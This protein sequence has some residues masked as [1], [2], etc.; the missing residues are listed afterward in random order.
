MGFLLQSWQL[1]LRILPGCV[2]R[3]LRDGI[4]G[5][6]TET[7]TGERQLASRELN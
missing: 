6:R 7:P 5:L 1:D 2:N 4:V 3:E